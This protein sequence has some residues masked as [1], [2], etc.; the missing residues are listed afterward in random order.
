MQAGA[1]R[2]PRRAALRSRNLKRRNLVFDEPKPLVLEVPNVGS[3]ILPTS[4]ARARL[5]AATPLHPKHSLVA[6]QTTRP[7]GRGRPRKS[8]ARRTSELVEKDLTREDRSC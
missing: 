1:G 6:K 8:V 3:V 7:P 4:F 5:S 2:L